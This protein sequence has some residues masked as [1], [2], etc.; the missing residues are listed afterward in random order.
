LGLFAR[1]ATVEAGTGRT[2][3]STVK[4]AAA[5]LIVQR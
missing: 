2:P 5:V 3:N 1:V 4:G